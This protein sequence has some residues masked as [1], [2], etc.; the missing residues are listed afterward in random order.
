MSAKTTGRT[1]G[2][3]FLLAYV[4]YLVGAL[5]GA[6]SAS[7]VVLAH[8]AGHQAQISAGALMMLANCAAVIGVGVLIFPILKRHHHN[9][10]YGCLTAQMAK[11]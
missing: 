11:G 7:T 4:V 1:V 5:A 6:G 3:L 8:V 10:A 9:S 2:V